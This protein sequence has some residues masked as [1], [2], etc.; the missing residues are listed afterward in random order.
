MEAIGITA[1]AFG[2]LFIVI[3]S[4]LITP[5]ILQF[6]WN[7]VIPDIF[8]LPKLTFWQAFWLH[9]VVQIILPS[10]RII[11]IPKIIEKFKTK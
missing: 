11:D 7:E 6:S 3:A 10:C 1:L 5:L 9:I 8:K 2:G 4:F